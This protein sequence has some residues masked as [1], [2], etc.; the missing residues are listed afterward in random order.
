VPTSV[1][2]P[3][4]PAPTSRSS[5][6]WRCSDPAPR[7]GRGAARASDERRAAC[8]DRGVE[9]AGQGEGHLDGRAREVEVRPLEHAH[10]AGGDAGSGSSRV[11][12]G[13]LLTRGA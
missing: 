10:L 9:V 3:G 12:A 13:S 1:A 8:L 6:C 7:A 4:P 5:T 2:R 11:S